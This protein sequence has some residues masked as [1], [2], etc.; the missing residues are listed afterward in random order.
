VRYYTIAEIAKARGSTKVRASYESWRW[1][2]FAKVKD[3]RLRIQAR[4]AGKA[5]SVEYYFDLFY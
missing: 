3:L 4:V 5:V 1:L 2:G